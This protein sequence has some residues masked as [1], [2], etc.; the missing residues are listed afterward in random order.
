MPT[1][2]VTHAAHFLGPGA[3]AALRDEGASL[4]CHDASFTEADA[5]AA[6]ETR[7]GGAI[8]LRAQTPDAIADEIA[9]RGVVL[10]AVVSND[11]HPNTPTPIEDIPADAIGTSVEALFRF[12]VRLTQ[13]LLP[14]MKQRRAGRFV[15]VTSARYRQPE[16]G[17]ALATSVRHATTAF[18]QA[19]AK[20]AAPFGVQANVVAPNYIYSEAY[21]P[22]G[23]FIDDPAGRADIAARVPLG[24]L[25]D[26]EEAGALIAFLSLGRCGFL[27]GQVVD[28][29][30]GW[31]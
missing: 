12:P 18:A 17:F 3:V 21:Y 1:V 25:G 26:Q 4:V 19:L 30:G 27:T 13:R 9:D 14:A 7:H 22:K 29:T 11:V 10:D 24:R 16:P 31:P 28:L 15:F 23:R 8:A 2:L 20:E 6:F 5:A